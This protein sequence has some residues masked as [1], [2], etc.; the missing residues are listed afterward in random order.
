LPSFEELKKVKL[1]KNQVNISF[2]SV[3]ISS[4]QAD[5]DNCMGVTFFAEAGNFA[6]EYQTF[7][8]GSLGQ[9]RAMRRF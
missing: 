5:A 6:F 3:Y 4:T 9:V 8:K 7:L 2:G 1:V